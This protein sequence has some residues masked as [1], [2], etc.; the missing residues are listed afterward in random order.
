MIYEEDGC[1]SGGTVS[2][3]IAP[4]TVRLGDVIRRKE[5]EE[6]FHSDL[7]VKNVRVK[8]YKKGHSN[9]EF[10]RC[11]DKDQLKIDVINFFE[12]RCSKYGSLRIVEEDESIPE[13]E[14]IINRNCKHH[15]KWYFSELKQYGIQIIFRS[16]ET[17]CYVSV[18]Q[19]F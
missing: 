14:Y 10:S 18:Y 16:D 13:L 1:E 6:C 5:I 12:R 11:F 17:D 3:D 9:E 15:H 2:A 4:F 7:I 19:L 8:F